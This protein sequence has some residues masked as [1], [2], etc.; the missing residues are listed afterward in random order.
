MRDVWV[1]GVISNSEMMGIWSL[2]QSSGSSLT[3]AVRAK[4]GVLKVK[5]NLWPS[6]YLHRYSFLLAS[7]LE[8]EG[9]FYR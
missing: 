7:S 9:K 6:D 8:S 3:E 2:L 5:S 4:L 1:Q